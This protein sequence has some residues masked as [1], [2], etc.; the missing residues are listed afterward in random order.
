MRLA[1]RT[2]RQQQ[3]AW[4]WT[5][6]RERRSEGSRSQWGPDVRKAPDWRGSEQD[7]EGRAP[8]GLAH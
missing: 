4:P 8:L 5:R 3:K 7:P 6:R 1:G 2:A